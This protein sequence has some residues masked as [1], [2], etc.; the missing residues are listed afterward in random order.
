M[1]Q[2]L[3][4]T[5][6]HLVA[7]GYDLY[8]ACQKELEQFENIS[9]HVGDILKFSGD[10]IVSPANSFGYMDGGLDL[11][12]SQFFGWDLEK[13]LR[14]HIEEEFFGE[15]P[16]GNATIIDIEHGPFKYLI[17][18]PTMRVPMDVSKTTNAYLAFKAILENTIS[19]NRINPSKQITSIYC[20]GLGTGEGKLPVDLFAKQVR[21]AYEAV[22]L[23][24]FVKQGGLV[25]AVNN[26]M[27][28]VG[29]NKS[30]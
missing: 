17:S 5:Q 4:K 29:Y 15:I 22:A 20:P 3:R 25:G 23:G 28:L 26:H 2:F 11:K 9:I 21:Y 30:E 18:A 8:D 6:I 10:A 16:V 14:K 12:Y 7:Y 1:N 24:N 13:R 19:H 27:D